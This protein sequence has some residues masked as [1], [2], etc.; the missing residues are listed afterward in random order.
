MPDWTKTGAIDR[1]NYSYR[2]EL[3]AKQKS[4]EREGLHPTIEIET[5]REWVD[6]WVNHLGGLPFCAQRLMDGSVK[7]LTVPEIHPQWFDPTYN[8]QQKLIA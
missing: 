7:E 4:A 5:A 1:K 6:Y 8:P 2:A 3:H